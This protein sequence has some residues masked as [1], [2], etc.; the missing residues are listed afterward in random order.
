VGEEPALFLSRSYTGH[1]HLAAF[2]VIDM[3]GRVYDPLTGQFFSPDPY[4]SFS[5][6]WVGYNRYLYAMGNPF[7]YTDPSGEWLVP[8]LIVA[9]IG[10]TTNYITYGITTGNWGMNA[11]YSGLIG[12]AISSLGY[13]GAGLSMNNALGAISHFSTSGALSYAGTGVLNAGLSFMMP[14]INIPLGDGFGISINPVAMMTSGIGSSAG[15]GFRLGVGVNASMK[16]GDWTFSAGLS[17]QGRSLGNI[18]GGIGYDDG[19]TGLSYY[20]NWYM[21]GGAQRTGVVGFRSGDFSLRWENDVFAHSGDKFRSNAIELGIGN[22]FIGT[23][24][25]TT[26]HSDDNP[27]KTPNGSK[28]WNSDK[29]GTYSD[30]FVKASPAYFG[31]RSKYG[32]ARVGWND[33]YIGDF[34]Q[35]GFHRYFPGVKS[36]FFN[37][38]IENNSLPYVQFGRYLPYSL[39]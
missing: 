14:P 39:Y 4:I 27:K 37:H 9:G 16:V 33:P 26:D 15:G 3:N 18:Y 12:A 31:M 20:H 6:D 13:V 8:L 29:Y 38:D 36:P 2:G 24:V 5:G 21:Q 32:V 19:K 7:R 17:S 30:G 22:Y 1:E 23:N 11:V 28:I 34:V 25:Y 35:N 10:F